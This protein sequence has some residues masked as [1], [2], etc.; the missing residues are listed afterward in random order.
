M[1]RALF[2][3]AGG[4]GF[5]YRSENFALQ[6]H[7]IPLLAVLDRQLEQPCLHCLPDETGPATFPS[8]DGAKPGTQGA[9]RFLGHDNGSPDVTHFMILRYRL[10]PGRLQQVSNER[11]ARLDAD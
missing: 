3:F 9:I 5:L 2:A 1:R 11:S 8:A 6:V 7:A 10:D 4:Q